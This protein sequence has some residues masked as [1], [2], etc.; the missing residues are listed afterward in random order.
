MFAGASG[1][2]SAASAER[3]GGRPDAPPTPATTAPATRFRTSTAG[4]V[5]TI[6][7]AVRRRCGRSRTGGGTGGLADGEA[8]V[9]LGRGVGRRPRGDT[10]R[11]R[12]VVDEGDEAS[13]ASG[14]PS[15]RASTVPSPLLRTQPPTSCDSA[16]LRVDSRKNTPCTEP[17]TTTRRATVSDTRESSAEDRGGAAEIRDPAPDVRDLLSVAH[18]R[19]SSLSTGPCAVPGQLQTP[20]AHVAR[21]CHGE[22]RPLPIA[23]LAIA[24]LPPVALAVAR[25]RDVRC[26]LSVTRSGA[27]HRRPARRRAERTTRSARAAGPSARPDVPRPL[28]RSRPPRDHPV[29][30]ARGPTPRRPGPHPPPRRRRFAR[31]ARR[32][33]LGGPLAAVALAAL[34]AVAPRPSRPA[35][36][37]PPASAP[38]AAVPPTSAPRRSAPLGPRRR[39]AAHP[40]RRPRRPREGSWR[41][42]AA[43]PSSTSTRSRPHPAWSAVSTARSTGRRPGD[44]GRVALGSLSANAAALGLDPADLATLRLAR[45]TDGRRRHYLRWRQEAGGVPLLDNDLRASVDADGRVSRSPAPRAP[46]WTRTPLTPAL[47]GADARDAVARTRASTMSHGHVR[48]DRPAPGHDLQHRRPRRPRPVRRRAA[49]SGSPGR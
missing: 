3:F 44:R 4:S 18:E 5:E 19:R 11:V 33:P 12:A 2:V 30:S 16:A 42:S 31:S 45:R 7:D 36:P 27:P 38:A 8:V 22:L 28:P 10:R 35:F 13:T 23:A 47:S 46:G 43:T 41:G 9:A 34:P 17:W 25:A 6:A 29:P 1:R 32:L 15:N 21:Q 48:P 37:R 40:S 14:A 26:P 20:G 24:V 49:T 39:P